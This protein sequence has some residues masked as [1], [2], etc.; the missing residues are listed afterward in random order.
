[1]LSDPFLTNEH[2]A[3]SFR[4]Q[5]TCNDLLLSVYDHSQTYDAKTIVLGRKLLLKS[6]LARIESTEQ[7]LD[8]SH[9]AG[10]RRI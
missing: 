4:E 5:D 2:H 10:E 9:G 3:D 8:S 7:V 6:I 1:M